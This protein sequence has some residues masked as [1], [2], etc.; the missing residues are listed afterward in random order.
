M[1]VSLRI[2]G[3]DQDGEGRMKKK[4]ILIIFICLI[5][6]AAAGFGAYR[7][8]YKTGGDALFFVGKKEV[9]RTVKMKKLSLIPNGEQSQELTVKAD[10]S[11]EFSFTFEF[12]KTK[13][14][15]L[16]PFVTVEIFLGE[17]SLGEKGLTELLAGEDVFAK[18]A[19]E[20]GETVQITFFYRMG[21]FGDEAQGT[22]V[23]FEIDVTAKKA[24]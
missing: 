21:D 17:T 11:G 23:G 2:F 9:T 1:K 16:A 20:Q 8:L 15:G 18:T 22:S 12:E 19:L 24:D 6:I 3:G 5:T 14:G 10:A 13:D 4:A 7:L